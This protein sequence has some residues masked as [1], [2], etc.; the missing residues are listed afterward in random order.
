MNP[1]YYPWLALAV[2]DLIACCVYWRRWKKQFSR[3]DAETQ[4]RDRKT[5]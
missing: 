5:A 2:V 3:R 4:G 1:T